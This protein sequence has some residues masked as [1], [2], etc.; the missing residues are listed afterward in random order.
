MGFPCACLTQ[1]LDKDS[2][3]LLQTTVKSAAYIRCQK[4]VLTSIFS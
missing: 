2:R 4:Q 3:L 1:L